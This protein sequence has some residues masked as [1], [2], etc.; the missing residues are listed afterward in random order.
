MVQGQPHGVWGSTKGTSTGSTITYNDGVR[1]RLKQIWKRSDAMKH[2][3]LQG[4]R[5][6]RQK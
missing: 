4:I 1:I 5:N 3:C 6:Y 2:K